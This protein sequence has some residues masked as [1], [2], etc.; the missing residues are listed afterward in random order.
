MSELLRHVV[1]LALGAAISP[2]VLTVAVLTLTAKQRPIARGIAFTAGVSAVLAILTAVGLTVMSSVTE[3]PSHTQRA[4]SDGVDVVIGLALLALAASTLLRHQVP[5]ENAPDEDAKAPAPAPAP[6]PE[7]TGLGRSFV[8][9]MLVMATNVTTI[10]LYIPAMK[11]ISKSGVSDTD[12]ALVVV[13]VMLIV[14][15]P[16]WLPLVV[17]CVAP[18][19]STRVLGNLNDAIQRHRRVIVLAVELVFGVYL[20]VKGLG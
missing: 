20:L 2:A 10:M 6:A 18:G 4:V 1:P 9:G 13:L 16:A 7:R 5:V 12:K 19:P 14:A 8:I 17:R 15:L 11:D 3:H